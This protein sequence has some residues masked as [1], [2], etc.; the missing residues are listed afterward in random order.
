MSRI[1]QTGSAS[2]A[3]AAAETPCFVLLLLRVAAAAA[4]PLLVA[5]LSAEGAAAFSPSVSSG[6]GALSTTKASCR[7]VGGAAGI[8]SSLYSTAEDEKVEG[9]ESSAD[10]GVLATTDEEDDDDEDE[11]EWVYE[12]YTDL[13]EPDFY[14]SE[15]KIGTVWNDRPNEIKETWVRLIVDDGGGGPGASSTNVAVW[16]DGARGKWNIDVP[17]QFFSVSK[18]SFGGWLGKRIY[19]GNADDYYYLQGTVRGWSPIASASVL[20]QWQMKRLGVDRDEA[21]VAPWFQEE[22]EDD[23]EEE[24]ENVQGSGAIEQVEAIKEGE[25]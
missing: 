23:S 1:R 18:E 21:G 6:N 11:E 20:G 7:S 16:G 13:T 19:A 24:E 4:L 25:Q 17:S 10:G 12:E 3:A 9:S 8:G 5:V 15:W 22:E 14:N 2:A